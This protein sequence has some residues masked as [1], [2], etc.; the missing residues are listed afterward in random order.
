MVDTDLGA[1][2]APA[3]R[4]DTAQDGLGDDGSQVKI[5]LHYAHQV[6]QISTG[7]IAGVG[8]LHTS[9]RGPQYT[10]ILYSK[11]SKVQQSRSVPHA[12]NNDMLCESRNQTQCTTATNVA[13]STFPTVSKHQNGLLSKMVGFKVGGI[14]LLAYQP[15]LSL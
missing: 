6:H 11:E 15:L 13:P 7:Y 1:C 5:K 2:C 14:K 12:I 4:C 9:R 3:E 10:T 8:P